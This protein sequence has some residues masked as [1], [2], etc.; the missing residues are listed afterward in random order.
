MA[1]SLEIIWF[2]VLDIA[3]QSNA[4]TYAHLLAFVLVS[5]AIGSAIGAKAVNYIRQPKKVFLLIQGMVTA[6]SAIAIWLIGLYWQNNP[7]LRSD[8]GFIEIDNLTWAGIF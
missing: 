7:Q 8:I 5:N 4:Y 6:Y 2:R 1:I 3:L